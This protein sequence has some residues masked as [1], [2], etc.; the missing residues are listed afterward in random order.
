MQIKKSN[1]FIALLL[2]LLMLIYSVFPLI[3]A[4]EFLI[5][6]LAPCS[7][8]TIISSLKASNF[9]PFVFSWLITSSKLGSEW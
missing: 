5:S 6:P 3:I 2:S 4:G 9:V 8:L 1:R 7:T